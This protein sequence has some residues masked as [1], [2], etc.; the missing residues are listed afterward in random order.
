MMLRKE[1]LKEGVKY[2]F[3]NSNSNHSSISY[4]MDRLK[5]MRNEVINGKA[6]SILI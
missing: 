1:I 4:K 2:L 5:L 6:T 3:E